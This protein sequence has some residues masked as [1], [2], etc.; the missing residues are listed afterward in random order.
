VW[1]VTIIIHYAA[2]MTHHLHESVDH[3]IMLHFNSRS[4]SS[5]SSCCCICCA[6]HPSTDAT[7]KKQWSHYPIHHCIDDVDVLLLLCNTAT[8]YTL[9]SHISVAFTM[10]T[11]SS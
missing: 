7:W 6:Y 3:I 10:Y 5:S 4:S 9:E 1:Q 11:M 2:M 8:T